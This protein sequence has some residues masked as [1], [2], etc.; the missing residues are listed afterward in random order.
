[1]IKFLKRLAL[2]CLIVTVGA[3]LTDFIISSGLKKSEWGDLKVYNDIYARK[4]NATIAIYGSSRAWQHIN[5][6]ALEDSFHI[7]A[8]NLGGSGYTF[9]LQYLRHKILIKHNP[10]PNIIIHSLDYMTFYKNAP[11]ANK[12]QY[13]P[14]VFQDTDMY[15][16][17]ATYKT[18]KP[19]LILPGLRYR[20]RIG[21]I[22][23]AFRKLC[24]IKGKIADRRK[25]YY[26]HQANKPFV[27]FLSVS[28]DRKFDKQQILLFEK[29]IIECKKSN[30]KLIF[31]YTPQYVEGNS[32]LKN[33]WLKA[34]NFFNLYAK[35]YCIPVY[36]YTK[37][38]SIFLKKHFR[39]PMHLNKEGTDL[40][41]KTFITDLKKDKQ[42]TL[43]Q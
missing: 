9:K 13:L 33:D 17:M 2:F 26:I 30:T 20:G 38:S 12:S 35:K 37:D 43:N 22:K 3:Y 5:P 40:F 4:V 42:I 29:Y 18:F 19:E 1:M 16:V 39:D 11:L 25:G 6:Y 36:D 10:K 7:P 23:E 14:Y 24:G 15:N 32:I 41:N 8:Y 34:V 31:V 28:R 21:D 27:N